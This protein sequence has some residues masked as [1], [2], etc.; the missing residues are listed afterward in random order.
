VYSNQLITTAINIT[1]TQLGVIEFLK[2]MAK[3]MLT[4]IQNSSNIRKR[5]KYGKMRKVSMEDVK[6]RNMDN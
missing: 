4:L 6:L 1:F 2:I 5:K 3:Y